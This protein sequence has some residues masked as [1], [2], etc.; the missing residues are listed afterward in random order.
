MIA[1]YEIAGYVGGL[2]IGTDPPA[3]NITG[4][5]TKHGDGACDLAPLFGWTNA[6]FV[7][8]QRAGRSRAT[9]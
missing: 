8:L 2:V 7:S 9:C 4:F 1:Q 5:Y 3:E 6:K